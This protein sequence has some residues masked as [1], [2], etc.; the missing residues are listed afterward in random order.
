M[1]KSSKSKTVKTART[2]A[3]GK[4]PPGPE[5]STLQRRMKRALNN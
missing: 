4:T 2:K 5:K 3:L 1:V